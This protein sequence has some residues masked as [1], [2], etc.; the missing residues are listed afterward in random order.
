IELQVFNTFII[1][2]YGDCS[3]NRR[4]PSIHWQSLAKAPLARLLILTQVLI[5]IFKN[6]FLAYIQHMVFGCK[7][8]TSGC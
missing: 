1:I 4:F 5:N 7:I 3:S 6:I 8:I 2:S